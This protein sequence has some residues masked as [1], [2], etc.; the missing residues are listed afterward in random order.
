[1]AQIHSDNEENMFEID[2][3]EEL[4][5]LQKGLMEIRFN[6]AGV[7]WAIKGSPFLS[8][9]HERLVEAIIAY[10]DANG[11]PRKA[12]DWHDWRR[13]ETRVLEQPAIHD[14]LV[15]IWSELP[16]PEAKREAVAD[17]MRPF[18]FSVDNVNDMVA[19]IETESR[20]QSAT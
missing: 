13:F 2:N 6:A 14:Y 8:H 19:E 16:T 3:I 15:K 20:K 11:E 7:D 4:Y 1:M 10:H 18:T 5:A 17:Q 12:Q 9:I